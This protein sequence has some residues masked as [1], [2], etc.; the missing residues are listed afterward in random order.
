MLG[1]VALRPLCWGFGQA[2]R[3]DFR[4][5]HASGSH[6]PRLA[7]RYPP[8]TRFHQRVYHFIVQHVYHNT[9]IMSNVDRSATLGY[10]GLC[11]ELR[12]N[13]G[14]CLSSDALTP[15]YG[16]SNTAGME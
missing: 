8:P 1:V 14:F 12:S 4:R 15:G 13:E 16:K 9:P 6:P 11:R 3:K 10:N 2:L 7:A 5:L